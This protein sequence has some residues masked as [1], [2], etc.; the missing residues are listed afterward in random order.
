MKEGRQNDEGTTT[1]K[2]SDGNIQDLVYVKVAYEKPKTEGPVCA[3][4]L[5]MYMGAEMGG[6][7]SHL[8][9]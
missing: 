7:Q 4:C 9:Q 1:F 6:G 3:L 2:L 8:A 5:L